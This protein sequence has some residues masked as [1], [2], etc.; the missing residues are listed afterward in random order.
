MFYTSKLPKD[1]CLSESITS[2]VAF[3]LHLFHSYVLVQLPL[4]LSTWHSA[5]VLFVTGTYAETY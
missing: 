3:S 1:L 2:T 4:Y 5:L